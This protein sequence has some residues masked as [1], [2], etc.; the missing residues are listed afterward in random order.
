ML[1]KKEIRRRIKSEKA[2]FTAAQL[3]EMSARTCLLLEHHRAFRTASTVLLYHS[4]PDEVS[5]RSLIASYC[6][7]KTILLPAV[8]G[9]GRMELRVYQGDQQMKEGA[10]HISEPS[11]QPFTDYARI[12]LAV[13]PGVAFDAD[14]HR[15][16]RGKGFYDQL[17]CLPAFR[18]VRKLGLCFPFQLIPSLPTEAHDIN[19]DE[20]LCLSC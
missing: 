15:L 4:L 13:I 8:I 19:M 9:E 18:Q 17:L 11:T 7:M 12:N 1:E 3:K 16:G 20:V 14:G 2:R 6:H 10:F 5:T